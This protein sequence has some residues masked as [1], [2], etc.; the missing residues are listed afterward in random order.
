M[1][2]GTCPC[3]EAAKKRFA[4]VVVEE[5]PAL[6]HTQLLRCPLGLHIQRDSVDLQ[7]IGVGS[8]WSPV[9]RAGVCSSLAEQEHARS[10]RAS[11]RWHRVSRT[12]P[13]MGQRQGLASM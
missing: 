12:A 3:K 10:V 7:T 11:A 8:S 2:A 9:M 13:V 5:A 1:V 6:A 4:P